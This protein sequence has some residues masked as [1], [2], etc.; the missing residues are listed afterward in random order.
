MSD[1][2]DATER[3]RQLGFLLDELAER[4]SHNVILVEGRRDVGGLNLL[5]VHGEMIQV[6]S[7]D[8]VLHVAEQ[9]AR[10]GKEAIILT[11]W[12]RKGGQL[13]RLL[14]HYLACN[15]V[16]FDEERRVRMARIVK[17]EIK[18]VE[19]LPSYFSRLVREAGVT[20]PEG[21]RG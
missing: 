19:S 12:D 11:D 1:R 6:Q 13:S 20:G 7:R 5:G 15:G 4:P 8:G 10:E 3:L 16:P 21:F 2:W 18:D 9:L 14:K 17:G